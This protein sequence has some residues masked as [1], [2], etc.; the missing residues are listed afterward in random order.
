MKKQ[1]LPSV[2]RSASV[3][4]KREQKDGLKKGKSL[5]RPGANRAATALTILPYEKAYTCV[6]TYTKA[7]T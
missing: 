7:Y 3:L 4:N 2:S 1:L 6:N 5:T